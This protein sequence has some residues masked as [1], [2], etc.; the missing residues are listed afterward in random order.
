MSLERE[1]SLQVES[2]QHCW[3]KIPSRGGKGAGGCQGCNLPTQLFPEPWRA[4]SAPRG[5]GRRGSRALLMSPPSNP[6]SHP[7]SGTT[8]API[9]R[10]GKMTNPVLWRSSLELLSAESLQTSTLYNRSRAMFVVQEEQMEASNDDWSNADNI[11]KTGEE[12]MQQWLVQRLWPI[13][14]CTEDTWLCQQQWNWIL[15]TSVSRSWHFII[16]ANEDKSQR[17]G[18]EPGFEA[19][20]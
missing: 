3:E 2:K 9:P 19:K 11:Y 4:W 5:S 17:P 16:I 15:F 14:L 18:V 12:N 1:S 13:F 7:K 8:P 6:H 20:W 10:A